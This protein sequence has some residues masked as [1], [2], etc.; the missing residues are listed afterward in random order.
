MAYF[1]RNYYY[2]ERPWEPTFFE[3]EQKRRYEESRYLNYLRFYQ[4]PKKA[5]R[6][7]LYAD[8]YRARMEKGIDLDYA[9]L[10]ARSEN[11]MSIVRNHGWDRAFWRN[12]MPPRR[13]IIRFRRP[14]RSP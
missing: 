14:R 8:I 11:L 10:R 12:A 9:A 3:I 5:R 1:G 4:D 6:A 2:F 7:L 13:P